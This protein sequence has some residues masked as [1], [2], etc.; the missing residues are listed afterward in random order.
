LKR[1]NFFTFKPSLDSLLFWRYFKAYPA[2]PFKVNE[3]DN[4]C[5]SRIDATFSEHRVKL[6]RKRQA[7][8][9]LRLSAAPNQCKDQN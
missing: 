2:T 8:K 1:E 9:G 6:F 7:K 4:L 5:A 3:I